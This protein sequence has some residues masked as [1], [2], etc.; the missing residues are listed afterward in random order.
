MKKEKISDR[1][2][3]CDNVMENEYCRVYIFPDSKWRIGN[4]PLAT[5]IKINPVEKLS[6][7][8][9]GQQKQRRK[10]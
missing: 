3:G 5:H 8:R 4:C 6:K 1:C 9:A 7:K 2:L 10:K